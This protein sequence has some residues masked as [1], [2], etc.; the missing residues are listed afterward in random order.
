MDFGGLR[1]LGN[2]HLRRRHFSG[3]I[4]TEFQPK[5]SSI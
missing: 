2:V 1:P 3:H 4:L 5:M